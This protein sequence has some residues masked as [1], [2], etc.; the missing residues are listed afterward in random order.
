MRGGMIDLPNI[1][2]AEWNNFQTQISKIILPQTWKKS[3]NFE[4]MASVEQS[5][6][7]HG[8]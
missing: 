1:E 7:I 5:D 3:L 6:K 4:I 2:K 8:E